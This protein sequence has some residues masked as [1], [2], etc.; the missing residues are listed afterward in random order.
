MEFSDKLPDGNVNITQESPLKEFALLL[1]GVFGIALA[2]Y[3]L[4]G[5]L[6]D[7]SIRHLSPEQ[8]QA[9]TIPF[10]KEWFSNELPN[11][12]RALQDIVDRLQSE[13][14]R[15]P[16]NI[17]VYVV[18][19]EAVNAVA[20]P[21]GAI[22]VFSG[23][24]NGIKSENELTFVLGHELGHF[25]NK[26]HLKGMGRA[27]VLLVLSVI[28][29]GP[30]NSIGELILSSLNIVETGF[31]REQESDAEAFALEITQCRYNHVGGA[32]DFFDALIREEDVTGFYSHF[33]TSH[34]DSRQRIQDLKDQTSRAGYLEKTT[35]PYPPPENKT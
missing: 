32:T 31:S 26:D 16:Y 35:L 21:G 6:I 29:L 30:D 18:Q 20:L 23:L 2:V 5:S 17:K 34:P 14:A 19:N 27:L 9:L 11:E 24:L 10:G 3:F 7:F 4:L 33:F 12:S 28:L 15:L 8:E 1:S 22:L 25:K 13:C